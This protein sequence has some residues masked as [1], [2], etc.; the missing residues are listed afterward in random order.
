[1]YF[2]TEKNACLEDFNKLFMLYTSIKPNKKIVIFLPFC[3]NIFL[4]Q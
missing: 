2:L 1:M 3:H 4:F